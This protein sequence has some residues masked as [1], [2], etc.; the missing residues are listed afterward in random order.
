MLSLN[1]ISRFHVDLS[2]RITSEYTIDKK[3]YKEKKRKKFEQTL[4][5]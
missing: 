5:F 2:S 3:F 4:F 1:L